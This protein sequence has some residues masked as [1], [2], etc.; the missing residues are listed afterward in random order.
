MAPLERTVPENS[1]EEKLREI[2]RLNTQ[3]D[4]FRFMKR[5]TE[6]YGARAFMVVNL[7]P[8]TSMTL[9]SS[10]VITSLPADLISAFDKEGLL[11]S[12]PVLK[13]LRES[14]VPFP[15]DIA[16]ISRQRG[17]KASEE[18]FRRYGLTHGAHFPVQ[19]ATGLRG[20]VALIGDGTV[21][22]LQQ[23]LEL[24]YLSG[25]IYE[26]LGRIR[27]LTVRIV[28]TLTDRE[29]DCLNWTAAG[30]T[31]AEIAEILGLSEHTVNHY[32]NRAAKKLDTVN[33]TQAVAKA[34]RTGLIK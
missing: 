14:A 27:S 15:L 16:E 30:K 13:R 10:T 8:L 23:M 24:N 31:S 7:P 17:N 28:D 26:M 11:S 6:D 19:D 29:I 22:D 25:H 3:F 9:S 5:L 32:L 34:L 4:V 18:I 20:S 33:R 21:F 1:M 2:A 12:S